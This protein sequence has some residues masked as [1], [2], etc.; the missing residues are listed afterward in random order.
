MGN[1]DDRMDLILSGNWRKG[2]TPE[3]WDGKSAKRI[4]NILK[5]LELREVRPDVFNKAL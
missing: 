5:K 3:L 2:G 1:I 4:V